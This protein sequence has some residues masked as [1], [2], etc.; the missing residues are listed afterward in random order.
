[1]LRRRQTDGLGLLFAPV[2]EAAEPGAELEEPGI[3]LVVKS[4]WHRYHKY[5]TTIYWFP[6]PS[7]ST[8]ARTDTAASPPVVVRDR[9]RAGPGR[10]RGG[11]RAD[12]PHRAAHEP[13]T[14]PPL[15][16]EAAVVPRCR[17]R[18]HG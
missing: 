14:A 6:N 4:A 7:R 5:R 3:R 11:I 12:P 17:L 8:D 9:G 2:Q 16:L 18:S 10:R 1:M 15:R 13:G